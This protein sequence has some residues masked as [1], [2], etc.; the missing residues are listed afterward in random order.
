MENYF[1][2]HFNPPPL[3]LWGNSF[4]RR[5]FRKIPYHYHIVYQDCSQYNIYTKSK[6]CTQHSLNID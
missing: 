3:P 2:A 6:H 5:L 4:N 1:S